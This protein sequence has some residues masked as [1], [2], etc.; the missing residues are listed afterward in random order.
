MPIYHVQE[1]YAIVQAICPDPF[2]ARVMTAAVLAESGGNSAAV[3]DGGRSRGWYQIHDIHGLDTP[4]RHDPV[5]STQ[6]AYGHLFLPA[7]TMGQARGYTD[8]QLA[9]FT[10]LQAER[11][12]GY[13]NPD[14]P[15]WDSAAAARFR[16]QWQRVL[17]EVPWAA[18]QEAVWAHRDDWPTARYRLH[19][20]PDGITTLDCSL[21]V[22]QVYAAAGYPF[23]AGI[24]TAE[25]IRQVCQ[26]IAWDALVPGDLLFFERTYAA[27]E[28]PGP[29]G[30]LATHVGLSA[31]AG[32]Y[33]MWD[34]H[35]RGALPAVGETDISTTYW[36]DHLFA[37]GRPYHV[38]Q[39]GD[40]MGR[41]AELE[42]LIG[43]LTHDVHAAL[44]AA[45]NDAAA[46]HAAL[47]QAR[48][49]RQ[50]QAAAAR[51]AGAAE[52][53]AAALATLQRGYPEEDAHGGDQA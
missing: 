29:D 8:E 31:G 22:L 20:P 42:S 12:Y 14:A 10:Y 6:W 49:A 40:D 50:R 1:I 33:R 7:Y 48:S 32:T 25:Q 5:A 35:E 24:R 4:T 37:A 34:A 38:V 3:G 51:W 53:M 23:P 16:A 47:L 44:A 27:T 26:P 46:A 21:Y 19:P 28:P 45:W 18:W 39:E 15:G 30:R 43:Y 41:V 13:R 17:A 52:A 36:Q 9:V 2:L 11:P